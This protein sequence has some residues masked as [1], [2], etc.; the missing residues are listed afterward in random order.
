MDKKILNDSF[1]LF[2]MCFVIA[3]MEA[4]LENIG[5]FFNLHLINTDCLAFKMNDGHCNN[6]DNEIVLLLVSLL[7]S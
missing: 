7:R 5:L 6:D 2:A 1:I 4:C 3:D